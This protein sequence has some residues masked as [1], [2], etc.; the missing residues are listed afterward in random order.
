MLYI[1]AVFRLPE[2]DVL[3]GQSHNVTLGINNTSSG[4]ARSYVDANKM[5]VV[6]L[7]ILARVGRGLARALAGGT[8]V[9]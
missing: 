5:V 6:H 4:T 1:V 9:G 3:G 7:Q 2:T 8:T